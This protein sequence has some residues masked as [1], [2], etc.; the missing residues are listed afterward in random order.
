M[1]S[2]LFRDTIPTFLN[3]YCISA[4]ASTGVPVR[5]KEQYAFGI[6]LKYYPSI[7]DHVLNISPEKHRITLENARTNTRKNADRL[8]SIFGIDEQEDVELIAGISRY[9]DHPN[10]IEKR[11]RDE[12]FVKSIGVVLDIVAHIIEEPMAYPYLEQCSILRNLNRVIG[13]L[14]ALPMCETDAAELTDIE[15]HCAMKQCTRII[16]AAVDYHR[17]HGSGPVNLSKWIVHAALDM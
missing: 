12:A 15:A 3:D 8:Q 10:V 9:A 2:E 7:A 11:R 13:C 4:D 6:C 14:P 16:P 17:E 1:Q 5:Q